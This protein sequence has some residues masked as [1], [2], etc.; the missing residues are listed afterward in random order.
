MNILVTAGP[1]REYLDDIRF[2]SNGSSGRMGFACAEE[3]RKRGHRVRLVAGPTPIEP[4]RRA[5]RVE[6]TAEMLATVRKHFAWCDVLIMAAAVADFTPA[7]RAHGKIK[8]DKRTRT[9]RLVRTPDILATLAQ[10]KGRRRFVG[11]AV[12]AVNLERF[13]RDKMRRKRMDFIVANA[14]S[15]MGAANQSAREMHYRSRETMLARANSLLPRN[16]TRAMGVTAGQAVT[17]K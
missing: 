7:E 14:P 3:A 9:L 11:F 6:T 5:M 17:P 4:P 13:A 12:E 16:Q 8:K 10:R 15:A 1:T 2:I